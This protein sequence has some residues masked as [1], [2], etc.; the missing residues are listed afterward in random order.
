VGAA[1]V[2]LA[3]GSRWRVDGIGS[4]LEDAPAFD[5]AFIALTPDDYFSGAP[6]GK[7]VLVYDDEHY[8]MAGALAETLFAK[9]HRVTLVTT[10][11]VVSSWTAMTD[12]Q[13]F[14]QRRLMELGVEIV[15]S[16]FL[17][18]AGDGLAEFACA[19]SGKVKALRFDTMVLVTGRLPVESLHEELSRED[20]A[21]TGIRTI[22]RIGDCFA[23]SSIADAVFNGHRCA[24]ELGEPVSSSP[25][26]RERPH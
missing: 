26:R 12:E 1:H 11:P 13:Y 5:P 23:P 18:T 21:A 14:I 19:Y 22:V 16:H 6:F 7:H 25:V 3:T 8:S 10:M 9:G 2:V 24:R 15:V 17:S 20:A 4:V